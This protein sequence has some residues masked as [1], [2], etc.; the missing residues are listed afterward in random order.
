LERQSIARFFEI[1]FCFSITSAADELIN[2]HLILG[3]IIGR[4]GFDHL[5]SI[6]NLGPDLLFREAVCESMLADVIFS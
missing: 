6:G 2:P 1:A 3:R 5:M 4:K